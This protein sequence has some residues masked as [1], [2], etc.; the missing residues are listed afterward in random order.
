MGVY[1]IH[2]HT[3]PTDMQKRAKRSLLPLHFIKI[4]VW[5]ASGETKRTK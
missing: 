2:F 5:S 1:S 3:S 4:L